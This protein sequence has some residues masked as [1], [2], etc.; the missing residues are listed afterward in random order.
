[1]RSPTRPAAVHIRDLKRGYLPIVLVTS[2]TGFGVGVAPKEA[3]TGMAG[4]QV[5]GMGQQDES[6]LVRAVGYLCLYR[7]WKPAALRLPSKSEIAS[8]HTMSCSCE[9]K[10]SKSLVGERR[11]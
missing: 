6:S 3:D 10:M 5:E 8:E 7:T 2:H 4:G 11:R 9:K 1:M